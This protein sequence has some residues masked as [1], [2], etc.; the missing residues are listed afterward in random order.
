MTSYRFFWI[1]VLLLLGITGCKEEKIDASSMPYRIDLST[2][3][4]EVGYPNRAVRFAVQLFVADGI[5]KAEIRQD[6]RVLEGSEQAFDGHPDTA[7]YLFEFVPKR[8]DIGRTLNFAI[9]AYGSQGNTGTAVYKLRIEEAPINIQFVFPDELPTEAEVGDELSFNVTVTS[10]MALNQLQVFMD[11]QELTELRQTEFE[12]PLNVQFPFAYTIST[13]DIG[14]TLNFVFRATD[15]EEKIQEA[16]YG[17]AVNGTRPASPLKE[18]EDM[19]LGGQRNTENGHFLKTKTGQTYF[20]PGVAAICA[21]IDLLLFVSGAATGVNITAPSFANAS[22]VYSAAHS[23]AT[24]ALSAWPVR[25]A[26]QLKR[27]AGMSSS[28]FKTLSTDEE[29]VQLFEDGGETTDNVNRIAVDDV[30]ALKT[31]DDRYGI[32]WVKE[33]PAGN[34]G[35]IR[36]DLKMQE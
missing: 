13:D 36:F 33:L 28:D 27:L 35:S 9:V 32:L 30:I 5:T 14:N 7:E 6:F 17:V 16:N 26:T 10:E 22:I 31:V 2:D 12:D 8:S 1:G 29:V 21:E 4:P 3:A 11:N 34:T 19:L 20:S 24:D 25:N 23:N 15:N 18:Y